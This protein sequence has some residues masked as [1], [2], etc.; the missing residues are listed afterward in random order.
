MSMRACVCALIVCGIYYMYK[1]NCWKG[2]NKIYNKTKTK[3]CLIF[4]IL[5]STCVYNIPMKK[6]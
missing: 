6:G 2:K 4:I 5:Q 3:F 1:F